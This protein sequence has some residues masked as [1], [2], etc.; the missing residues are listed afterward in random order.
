[1][2]TKTTGHTP[3]PWE[4]SEVQGTWDVCRA[5][6]GDMIADLTGNPRGEVDALLIASAPD[7]LEACRRLVGISWSQ[8]SLAFDNAVEQAR[9]AIAKAEGKEG[10]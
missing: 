2:S 8:G 1:M 9:A 10:R 5:G 4:T 7:L 6:G 3:G